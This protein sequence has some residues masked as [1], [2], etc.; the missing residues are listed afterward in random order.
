ML[1]WAVTSLHDIFPEIRWVN[2]TDLETALGNSP[3]KKLL[4]TFTHDLFIRESRCRK[5]IVGVRFLGLGST[6]IRE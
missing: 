3:P 6:V 2:A 1:L 4:K 5:G